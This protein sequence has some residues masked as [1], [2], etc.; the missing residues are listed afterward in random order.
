MLIYNIIYL[1]N[2]VLCLGYRQGLPVRILLG[3]GE[4]ERRFLEIYR[5]RVVDI[6]IPRKTSSF[7]PS[8]VVKIINFQFPVRSLRPVRFEKFFSFLSK[9]ELSITS[10]EIA[11]CFNKP[12]LL[13]LQHR[14]LSPADEWWVASMEYARA[15]QRRQR[16]S[17]EGKGGQD[18]GKESGKW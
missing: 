12:H 9:E 11:W 2:C 8:H 4:T 17:Y 3:M 6:C 18:W 13:S 10:L 1:F 7:K 14:L 16:R 15:L 5:R